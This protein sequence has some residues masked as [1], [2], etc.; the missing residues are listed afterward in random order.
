M[1]KAKLR[2]GFGFENVFVFR[3]DSSLIREIHPDYDAYFLL[4][5]ES[6][7]NYKK[8]FGIDLKEGNLIVRKLFNEEEVYAPYLKA[9]ISKKIGEPLQL[10]F[11]DEESPCIKNPPEVL[12]EKNRFW[13]KTLEKISI[14]FLKS[15]AEGEVGVPISGGKDSTAALILATKAFPR[16]KALYVK[17]SHEMPYTDEYV[18]ELCKALGVT[19]VKREVQFDV[20]RLGLPSHENRWCTELKIKALKEIATPTLIAGDREAESRTRRRRKEVE[21][22]IAKELFPLKYWSGAMVQ[23]Y[24]LMHG[25]RLH[26]FYYKGFYRIGCTICPSLSEWEKGILAQIK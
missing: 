14:E 19:L 11:Y 24:I 26:P 21:H 3:A 8:F 18:E 6:E 16:V 9:V 7:L 15:Q 22:R 25:I 13:L 5:K 1:A 2:L 4:G 20:E 12:V 10:I 17:V 23:L